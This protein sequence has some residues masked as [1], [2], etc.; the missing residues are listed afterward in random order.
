MKALLKIPLSRYSGYGNDGIGLAQAMIRR[1]V[2]V[3]ISPTHV[4][5]PLPEDVAMLLTK[6]L[7]APF[8]LFINHVDPMALEAK[9]E[10]VQ[11]TGVSVGWTMWE[12]S[13][14]LNIGKKSRK[15]M[16]DRLEHFDAVVGYSPI[17]RDCLEPYYSGPIIIQ[18][19]G[20][21]S[22]DWPELQRDWGSKEFYFFMIG[23][24]SERKDPFRALEAFRIAKSRDPEFDRWARLSLKTT[25]PGLHHKIED[26]YRQNDPVTGE[27]YSSVRVFYDIWPTEVVK[28]FYRVQHVLL[29]PSRGEGKNMPALEFMSTGGTVIATNWAGHTQWLNPEYSYP[30]NYTLEPVDTKHRETFNARADVEHLVELMLHCFHNRDEVRQKG[31]VAA[32]VIPASHSWDKVVENLLL[33]LRTDVPEKGERLWQLAQLALQEAPHANG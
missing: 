31:Y 15:T 11:H 22:T 6:E 4:D 25:A 30:L 10:V 21:D 20:F 26:L 16:K 28:E 29:A 9:E 19:G 24:L 2:D 8:D 3:Y 14:Y 13:N 17:D 1:G 5:A 33:K 12:Y 32:Q 18:Q 7:K 27:E 23:V